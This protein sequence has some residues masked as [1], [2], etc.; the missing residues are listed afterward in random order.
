MY[1]YIIEVIESGADVFKILN[2]AG[3]DAELADL[4]ISNETESV[5][6]VRINIPFSVLNSMPERGSASFPKARGETA[7]EENNGNKY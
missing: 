2:D 1:N 6:D 7:S 5:S 4:A 3:E